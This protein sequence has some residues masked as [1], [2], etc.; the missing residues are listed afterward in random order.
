MKIKTLIQ[1]A[2]GNISIESP[3]NKN[4]EKKSGT[5]ITVGIPIKVI[6]SPD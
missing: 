6:E 5:K 1:A 3:L 2:G 4:D